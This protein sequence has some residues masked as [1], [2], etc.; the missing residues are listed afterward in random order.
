MPE[1]HGTN[2]EQRIARAR[3]AFKGGVTTDG[4]LYSWAKRKE[5]EA[6][7]AVTPSDRQAY[8]NAAEWG[9][10]AGHIEARE[11]AVIQSALSG[12]IDPDTG[13]H[14]VADL[15]VKVVIT[16]L[17]NELLALRGDA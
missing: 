4:K 11:Y 14:V 13:W 2:L 6:A 8:L 12:A 3:A 1:V 15:A 7:L 9:V 17:S 5:D 16:K 10:Q